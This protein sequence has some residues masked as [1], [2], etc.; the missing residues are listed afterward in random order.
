M[1]LAGNGL[2]MKDDRGMPVVGESAI[3]LFNANRGPVEFALPGSLP[4]R[5][6]QV[7]IDTSGERTDPDRRLTLPATCRLSAHSLALLVRVP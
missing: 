4:H 7:V 3:V 5:T 2:S 1:Y 6:W